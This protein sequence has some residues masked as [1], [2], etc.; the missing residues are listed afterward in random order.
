MKK[1]VFFLMLTIL[2]GQEYVGS[3]K[4]KSCH[5]KKFS[6]AQYKVWENSIHANAFETLKTPE[7]I[8]TAIGLGINTNPWETPECVRCHVTGFDNG[9]YEIKGDEFWSQ[10]TDKGKPTKEVKRMTGLQGVGCEA[11][12]G[13]G[14]KYKSKTKMEAIFYGDISGTKL[15]YTIP[16]ED[17]CKQCHNEK[18]PNFAGFK[19]EEKLHE[20][21]HPYPDGFRESKKTKY[22]S[23]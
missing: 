7:A 14:S 19:F 5:K 13:P 16:I 9:G 3:K 17:T 22:K 18:S 1:I 11:C 2:F 8:E 21:Q 20:I 15:G 10:I 23:K 4:C 6:G 12:H